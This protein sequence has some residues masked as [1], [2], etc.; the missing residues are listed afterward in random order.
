MRFDCDGSTPVMPAVEASKSGCAGASTPPEALRGIPID[1]CSPMY[2]TDLRLSSVIRL[3]ISRE[4]PLMV[5]RYA[6]VAAKSSE[7]STGG[8]IAAIRTVL[9]KSS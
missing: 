1:W 8:W 4:G 7:A 3:E 9:E 2:F 5:K 6:V